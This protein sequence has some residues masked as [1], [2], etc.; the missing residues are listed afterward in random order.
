MS[1]HPASEGW[2]RLH[3]VT[4][5]V[6][7]GRIVPAFLL[8][9]VISTAHS[10]AENSTAETDYL[11]ILALGTVV[12]GYIHWMVTRWRIEGDA[13]RIETGLIRRDSKRLPI[14]RIQ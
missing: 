3:P 4:P 14:A 8:L 2:R 1:R 9:L 5:V 6:R 12:Y 10:A 11:V 13:L 7:A